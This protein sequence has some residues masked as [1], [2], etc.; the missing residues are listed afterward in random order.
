MTDPVVTSTA[1]L[2]ALTHLVTASPRLVKYLRQLDGLLRLA[3]RRDQRAASPYGERPVGLVV[4]ESVTADP[5]RRDDAQRGSQAAG[6][7]SP[8]YVPAATAPG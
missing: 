5:A 1:F 6:L 4:T 2:H 3:E 7:P 8:S